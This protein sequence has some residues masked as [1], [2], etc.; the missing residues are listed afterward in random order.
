M[1]TTTFRSSVMASCAVA[2]LMGGLQPS[3]AAAPAAACQ[4]RLHNL[5][6]AGGTESFASAMN[7][8]GTVVGAVQT[9]AG[10]HPARS[11]GEVFVDIS[12]SLP[13]PASAGRYLATAIND[14][15]DIAG[16][17][18]SP[19]WWPADRP[20]GLQMATPG[21]CAGG[22]FPL[23]VPG[24]ARDGALV[25]LNS[26]CS[27]EV[28]QLLAHAHP[29]AGR[30]QPAPLTD[31][32]LYPALAPR[33]NARG[34]TIWTVHVNHASCS[35]GLLARRSSEGGFEPAAFQGTDDG[36]RTCSELGGLNDKGW[37]A[38]TALQGGPNQPP[39]LPQ[40]F[41]RDTR[42][43]RLALLTSP[44]SPTGASW[45]HGLSASGRWVA[46]A[47]AMDAD[48]L[49]PPRAV[50]YRLRG[51]LEG[52]YDGELLPLDLPVTVTASWAVQIND[53]GQVLGLA[54]SADL[55]TMPSCNG[56]ISQRCGWSTCFR[57][58]RP[59]SPR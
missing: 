59:S 46:G 49:L 28:Q 18:D 15:G 9:V 12:A 16:M 37:L 43:G 53:Q 52:G 3:C 54:R 47:A 23:S 6:A 35:Q 27:V 44:L 13:G 8:Q 48:G 50:R 57:P 21:F 38:G 32:L 25:S 56:G 39:R 24:I 2:A 19:W 58:C 5:G 40:G 11:E 45:S 7:S 36:V 42:S 22:L 4:P 14:Q 31:V 10:Q 17:A 33:M 34:E 51:G 29:K 55:A 20:Q 41:V 26:G 1:K 30:Y